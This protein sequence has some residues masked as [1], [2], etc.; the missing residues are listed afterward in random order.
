M[1]AHRATILAAGAA[2]LMLAG[3][4]AAAQADRS[5]VLN[6]LVECAKIND[7]TARLA[8]YDNNIRAAGGPAR[9][10]VPG[11][12]SAP[13]GGGA[14]IA[15]GASPQ[16][17]GYEDVRTPERFNDAPTGQLHEI[18]SKI[19][20]IRQNGPGTYA[21]TLEGGAQWVFAEGVSSSYRVPHAGAIIEIERG[22]LGSFLMRFDGQGPVPVRRV[23]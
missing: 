11:R 22:S 7:P 18:S 15:S 9:S 17:F 23:K 8:C 4:P 3:A 13:V 2:T 1:R 16:G 5:A 20:G 14:P 21:F 12:G 19:T 10:T 6:I